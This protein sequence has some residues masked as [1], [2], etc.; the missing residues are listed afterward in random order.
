VLFFCFEAFVSFLLWGGWRSGRSWKV[1]WFV[2]FLLN[3]EEKDNV[4]GEEGRG[5][6]LKKKIGSKEGC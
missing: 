4:R 3:G 1:V 6:D 2:F 5:R